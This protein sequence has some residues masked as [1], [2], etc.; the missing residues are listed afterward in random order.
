LS[1]L[2]N[3]SARRYC[4]SRSR[5]GSRGCGCG[6]ARSS[7]RCRD[8]RTRR[9]RNRAW[10]A[11]GARVKLEALHSDLSTR[12]RRGIIKDAKSVAHEEL[13]R[14]IERIRRSEVRKGLPIRAIAEHR[15]LAPARRDI[16]GRAEVDASS[17]N[18]RRRDGRPSV[19]SLPRSTELETIRH[20]DG[21][22]PAIALDTDP[23]S[24]VAEHGEA[25]TVAV[26]HRAVE[27]L[28][29][30]CGCRAKYT[31]RECVASGKEVNRDW[32]GRLQDK[33]VPGGPR[34]IVRVVVPLPLRA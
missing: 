31:V 29:R 23:C 7:R 22:S 12:A 10:R 3:S 34:R 24:T 11:A 14:R 19:D 26:L 6:R 20:P 2:W 21:V 32:A 15:V 16:G 13:P 28:D 1:V 4:R 30:G 25:C 9:A 27:E 5:S 33:T 18:T 17:R 8:G